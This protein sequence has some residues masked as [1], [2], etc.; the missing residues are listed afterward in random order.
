MLSQEEMQPLIAVLC[1]ANAAQF[2]DAAQL[3]SPW[4]DKRNW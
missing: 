1:P 4:F 3:K 2:S